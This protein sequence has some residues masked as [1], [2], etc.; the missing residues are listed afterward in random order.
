MFQDTKIDMIT[1][2][3]ERICAAS[4]KNHPFFS[5]FDIEELYE[6]LTDG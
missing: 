5:H 4:V 1:L 3:N 2:V 6:K